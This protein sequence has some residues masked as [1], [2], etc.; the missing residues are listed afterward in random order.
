MIDNKLDSDD[1]MISE[2]DRNYLYLM[3]GES[4]ILRITGRRYYPNLPL[5]PANNLL[6]V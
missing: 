2:S 4:G 6:Y 3:V 5:D 1:V